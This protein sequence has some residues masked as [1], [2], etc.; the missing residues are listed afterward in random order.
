M[1]TRRVPFTGAAVR[2]D[3]IAAVVKRCLLLLVAVVMSAS[4]QGAPW[5]GFSSP[6]R[7]PVTASRVVIV[8]DL[9]RDG[10]P[11]LVLSG[12]QVDQFGSFSI[13]VNEGG[14]TFEAERLVPTGFGERIEDA[15]DI[16][17]DGMP[18]LIAS[19]YF[20]NGISIYRNTGP[21]VFGAQEFQGTAT[22]G[23]P[24]QIIDYDGDGVPDV[25]SL[26]F[27]SG[28][29]VRVHL[30]RGR[31]DGSLEPKVT[32]DTDLAVGASESTRVI[33]GVLEMLVSER[34]GN[35]G[36]IRLKKTGI[37]VERLYAG[38][39]FDLSCVFADVNGDGVSDIIDTSDEVGS[40]EPVFVTLGRA[41]GTFLE[42]KRI[43]QQRHLSFPVKVRAGDIDGDGAAD[44]VISDFQASTLSLFLGDGSGNFTQAPI[45]LDAGAPIN[46]F[47]LADLN[48]DG[49]LDVVTANDDHTASILKN[50]GRPAR[51]RAVRP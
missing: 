41:D 37:Q 20:Q 4:V 30:F 40:S 24:S 29:P 13:L 50:L 43:A 34:S 33:N 21:L 31:G 5:R 10:R 49:S 12:T 23:G 8:R 11:D 17:G 3:I 35:L 25:V 28:N 26:S 16:N 19:N 18:D 27:G 45:A 48:G 39:G 42:R 2:D 7:Y 36:L 47:E 46:D 44:L 1:A 14:G 9:N 38:P 6:S 22:H 51:H 15:A 32:L